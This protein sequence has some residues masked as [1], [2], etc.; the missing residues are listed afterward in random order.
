MEKELQEIGL[1]EQ[2]ADVYLQLLKEKYQEAS[3]IAKETHI[4]R[5]VVYSI[6]KSLISKGLASY[7]IRN[8]VKYFIAAEPK[9]LSDFLKDKEKTLQKI[10][11]RLEQIKP[12][13]KEEVVVEVYQGTKGGIT[14]LKDIIRTGKDCVVLG[15]DGTFEKMEYAKQFVRQLR[16]KN[17]KERILAKEGVKILT[18]KN[19]EVRYLSKEFQIPTITTVYGNKVALAVFTKPYYCI[20]IK[21]KDLADSYRSFFEILWRISKH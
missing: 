1:S 15:E 21:S 11:P 3:K 5:S 20:L 7:V 8:N 9:T 18:T 14:V 17:I 10:L 12:E 19:S 2:E 4:N 6:L 13:V 16:E